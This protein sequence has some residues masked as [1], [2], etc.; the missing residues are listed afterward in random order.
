LTARVERALVGL[1]RQ[2][3][4]HFVLA[5]LVIGDDGGVANSRCI[6]GLADLI[7]IHCLLEL[8]LNLR[9]TAE[10]DAQ[11]HRTAHPAN[12]MLPVP[13]HGDDAGHTEYHAECQE[14]PL[15]SQPV[16]AYCAKKFHLNLRLPV[17]G[18]PAAPGVQ[19]VF[20]SLPL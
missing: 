5:W 18:K 12:G 4:Q 3:D 14:I 10:I 1:F 2:A 13:T 9:S 19:S 8:H 15:L 17:A 7:H 16:D 20:V 6:R 11:R